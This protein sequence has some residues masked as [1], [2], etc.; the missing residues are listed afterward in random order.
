MWYIV[1]IYLYVI[2]NSYL[3]IYLLNWISFLVQTRYKSHNK[4]VF[5]VNR[6]SLQ[7]IWSTTSKF[8]QNYWTKFISKISSNLTD[9]WSYPRSFLDITVCPKSSDPFYVVTYYFKWVNTSWTHSTCHYGSVRFTRL[10]N[11]AFSSQYT[12]INRVL[13]G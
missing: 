4:N 7:S 12:L 5:K 13:G 8:H 2:C 6:F 3:E 11:T 9:R 1:L 10:H